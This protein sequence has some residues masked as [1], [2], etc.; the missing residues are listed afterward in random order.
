MARVTLTAYAEDCP[1]SGIA[2]ASVCDFS[3]GSLSRE[4][5]IALFLCMRETDVA[6]ASDVR[7]RRKRRLDSRLASET[8]PPTRGSVRQPL[9]SPADLAAYLAVPLATVYRWRSRSE[10]PLGYRVGR[11]VRY[12]LDDVER[13]LEGHIDAS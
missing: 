7:A 8:E 10:G 9:L 6:M 3:L 12:R 1:V 13:W 4:G 5:L 2:D 11:H